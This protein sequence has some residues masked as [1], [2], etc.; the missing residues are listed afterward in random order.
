VHL[1]THSEVAIARHVKVSGNRSPYDGDWVYWSTRRGWHPKANSRLAK[2]LKE[3]RGRC[4]YCG[5][6][7]QHDD[8]IEIDH[9]NGDR[10]NSRYSNLQA[11]HG[12]CHDAKTREYGDYLPPGMRD[13]HQDTEERGDA[14]V[15]C[16]ALNQR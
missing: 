3:Q 2:L 7:F 15:S 5:L 9:I 14:K 4:R 1:R 12:H 8:R 11:L 6:F 10:R 13:K 16:T